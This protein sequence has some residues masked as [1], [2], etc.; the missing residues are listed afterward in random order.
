MTPNMPKELNNG[1]VEA[2]R[3]AGVGG[4]SVGNSETFRPQAR[5]RTGDTILCYYAT[6]TPASAV[7]HIGRVI[8]IMRMLRVLSI[9]TCCSEHQMMNTVCY[10]GAILT[11]IYTVDSYRHILQSASYR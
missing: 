3:M 1:D 7:P 2:I 9:R 8:K 6:C 4:A 11:M 5:L 10:Q